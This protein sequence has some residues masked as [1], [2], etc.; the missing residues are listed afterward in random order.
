M[1][2]T[3]IL[4]TPVALLVLVATIA[5]SIMG[6]GNPR[7][8]DALILDV[9]AIVKRR[10]YHRLLT[11]GFVHG[12]PLHLFMNMLT[13]FFLGPGLERMAGS[14]GFAIIYFASL[15]AGSAWAVMEHLRSASY[16]ALG[17]SGAVSGVTVVFALFAPFAQIIVFILPMPAIVFAVLYIAWS[18]YAS[19]R[20][21]D[22]IGH[23]A[24]LGGALM[25]LVLTC[26]IWPTAIENLIGELHSM[27][28]G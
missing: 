22:G 25:G 15:L 20:V 24:H 18:A 27:F 14:T 7:F 17:A 23:E 9:H 8:T 19:G 13:L 6:F 28:G 2:L 12:D 5:I 10:E 21:N 16:R 4:H 1:S 3:D 26:L 11:S